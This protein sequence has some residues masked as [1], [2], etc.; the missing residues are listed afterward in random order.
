MNNQIKKSKRNSLPSYSYKKS[1]QNN[2]KYKQ[3]SIK[4]NTTLECGFQMV[5]EI[6]STKLCACAERKSKKYFV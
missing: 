2:G 3:C 1:F 5:I 4:K 6:T